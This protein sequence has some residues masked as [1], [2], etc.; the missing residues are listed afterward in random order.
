MDRDRQMLNS[1]LW[2]S[3]K[4]GFSV[5]PVGQDKKPK[6]KWEGFQKTKATQDQIRQWWGSDFKG[7]NI[8]IVT[9]AISNL[10]VVDMD[11]AD[12]LDAIQPHVNGTKAPTASTP[13]G[14]H[15]YFRYADGVKNKTR[16]L[17]DCDV[18]S[19]GG[20]VV[21]PPSAIGQKQYAWVDGSS[22]RDTVIPDLP[23]SIKNILS[24]FI[25]MGDGVEGQNG[26]NEQQIVT[27]SNIGFGEG[28][29]DDTLFHL[30]NHLVKSGMPQSNIVQYLDFFAKHCTPPFPEREIKAKIASALARNKA[31]E[32]TVAQEVREFIE[33]TSGNFRVTDVEHWVTNGNKLS[34]KPILMALS[35]EVKAGNLEKLPG[36][37]LYR[38]LNE[39]FES[40]NIRD[41]KPG[42]WMDINLPFGLEQ[43]VHI[44]SGNLICIAGVTNA[45]KSAVMLN[46]VKD[47]MSK[48]KCWYFSSEMSKELIRTRVEKHEGNA[49]WDF[50]VIDNWSQSPD[51]VQPD[52]MN[53]LD[54]IDV[55]SDGQA[56]DIP[57]KLSQIQA[58]L[59]KGIA[60]VAMQ[61]KSGNEHAIGGEQT[62]SKASLYLT[63]DQEYPYAVMRVTKAKAFEEENPNGFMTKF[64]IYKGIN[65]FQEGCWGPEME[66]ERKNKYKDFKDGKR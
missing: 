20:Y 65:L 21:A 42:V 25:R 52:D 45:G 31:V 8:G 17:K 51:V 41:V 43:Y 15:M 64:K 3:E 58:K 1:A 37:G 32:K 34:N 26:N 47:N 28:L 63:I 22:I 48:R 16:F 62:K 23:I 5:I 35:R 6:L 29:R 33:V 44:A 66:E 39:K 53:F 40:T 12:G 61:K 46:M 13:K 4:M 50:D 2:Y 11:S 10:T 27:N 59:R 19:E 36:P 54:W 49:N 30:A 24:L 60:I 55:P 14:R 9:G 57:K 38:V 18:R 56:Y 7:A